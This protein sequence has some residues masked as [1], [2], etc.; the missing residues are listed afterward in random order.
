MH[1]RDKTTSVNTTKNNTTATEIYDDSKAMY[2]F[3]KPISDQIFTL[4]EFCLK[5]IGIQRYGADFVAPELSYP[6][7]FDFKT[8]EDYLKDISSALQNNL[9]PS[10]IQTILMQYINSFYGDNSKTTNIFRLVMSAD[11]LF[12]IS[13]DEIN[14]QLAKGTIA[15]WE[16][17]LH[18]SILS[19]INDSIQEDSEFLNKDVASQ[20]ETLRVA[21][22]T[23][24]DEIS[25]VLVNELTGTA[26]PTQSSNTLSESVGGLTGMIEIVKAVA[27]GVYDLDAAVAL[28][29]Q[30]FGISEEQARLQLGTPQIVNSEEKAATINAL[31]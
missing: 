3:I 29:S 21:A 10:F 26:I 30:R 16:Q 8:P 7:N 11:R 25:G 18:T 17:V 23:K 24:A 13:Q 20:I 27:S 6:K 31:T 9:P 4:Y 19:F 12:G 5:N 1:L 15:K 22:M 14:M 28:V 2:S